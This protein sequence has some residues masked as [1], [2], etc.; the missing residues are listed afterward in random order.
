[1]QRRRR[2]RGQHHS[3]QGNGT[4]GSPDVH[5][6][7]LPWGS[8]HQKR[9]R[10]A[11][12]KI[13]FW[14][15]VPTRGQKKGGLGS[16]GVKDTLV[17]LMDDGEHQQMLNLGKRT[18]YNTVQINALPFHSPLEA[19]L[20]EINLPLWRDKSK[21][22][23]FNKPLQRQAPI[24]TAPECFS[25]S[26]PS[27]LSLG[28]KEFLKRTW[29]GRR[30]HDSGPVFGMVFLCSVTRQLKDRTIIAGSLTAFA[31]PSQSSHTMR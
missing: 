6:W 27:G 28:E 10:R 4:K 24:H 15:K 11:D 31:H 19:N 16:F 21:R 3:H 18:V 29:Q 5:M 9:M 25:Y 22:P 17:V 2:G 1:M 30:S 14:R 8:V 23:H 26:Q 12:E 13:F 7:Y 20:C